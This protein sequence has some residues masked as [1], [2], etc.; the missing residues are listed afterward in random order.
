[1]FL[2]LKFKNINTTAIIFYSHFGLLWVHFK[3]KKR[4]FSSEGNKEVTNKI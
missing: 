4:D 2:V 3:S 1:M